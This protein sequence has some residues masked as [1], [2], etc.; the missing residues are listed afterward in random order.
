MLTIL[1]DIKCKASIGIV[2][3]PKKENIFAS[4]GTVI[5]FDR[6]RR[7]YIPKAEPIMNEKILL[8]LQLTRSTS[9]DIAKYNKNG[10]T[11]KSSVLLKVIGNL[12]L[13]E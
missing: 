11:G 5:F 2:F 6:V 12:Y 8:N 3:L 7:K 9:V 13:W 4:I 1:N 10:N